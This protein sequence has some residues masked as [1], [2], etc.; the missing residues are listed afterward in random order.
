[1]NRVSTR[2]NFALGLSVVLLAVLTASFAASD[3]DDR[4]RRWQEDQTRYSLID[5]EKALLKESDSL[6]KEVFEL[7]KTVNELL[8]AL[9]KKE[10]RMESLKHQLITVQMKL[11][12]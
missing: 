1:M 3:S 9:S 2:I 6:S 12:K 5:Q 11:L 8:N 10:D 4:E 7:K